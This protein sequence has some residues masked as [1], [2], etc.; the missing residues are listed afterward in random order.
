MPSKTEQRH[1]DLRNKLI[2]IAEQ[3]ITSNGLSA[4]RARDLA[5]QAGCSVGAIYTVFED[6]DKLTMQVNGRTFKRLGEKVGGAIDGMDDLPPTERLI[7]LAL[8]YLD[9]AKE[10]ARTW[11]ALFNVRMSRDSDVPAWYTSELGLLFAHISKPVAELRPD[12]P[13]DELILL[14]R[15]LFSSVHG[16]VLLG[17]QRRISGTPPEDLPIMIRLILSNLTTK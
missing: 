7:A 3:V 2:D 12:L 16:I 6:M 15:G 4:V 11:S 14:T 13:N 5:K 10:N 9:F 1:N 8:A 17:L